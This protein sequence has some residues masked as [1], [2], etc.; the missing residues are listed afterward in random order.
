MPEKDS[1]YTLGPDGWIEA[2]QIDIDRL[3]EMGLVARP[4][5]DGPGAFGGTPRSP[6][7]RC[8]VGRPRP[9]STCATGQAADRASVGFLER[10]ERRLRGR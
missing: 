1:T 8:G 7:K 9:S 10:I 4:G 6:T 5:G 2:H 3:R